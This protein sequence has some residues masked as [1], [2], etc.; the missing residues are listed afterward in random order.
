MRQISR[1][2][3]RE[4]DVAVRE[5]IPINYP[6]ARK[7][8][9]YLFVAAV[10][11]C[12]YQLVVFAISADQTR[13]FLRVKTAEETA[14][15]I[16]DYPAA[17]SGLDIPTVSATGLSIE[18]IIDTDYNA[19]IVGVDMQRLE[20]AKSEYDF[21]VK[22]V[23]DQIDFL[24]ENALN[25][26]LVNQAN[27]N[28]ELQYQRDLL[29][30][31]KERSQIIANHEE[32]LVELEIT[33]QFGDIEA[34]KKAAEVELYVAESE[35]AAGAAETDLKLYKRRAEAVYIATVFVLSLVSV[36]LLLLVVSYLLPLVVYNFKKPIVSQQQ[37]QMLPPPA[38]GSVPIPGELSGNAEN[39]GDGIEN[40]ARIPEDHLKVAALKKDFPWMERWF[41]ESELLAI[42]TLP[43]KDRPISIQETVAKLL[44]SQK[45]LKGKEGYISKAVIFSALGMGGPSYKWFW[46]MVNAFYGGKKKPKNKKPML[47]KKNKPVSVS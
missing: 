4:T 10:V 42:A 13:D 27:S 3:S 6:K 21:E 35:L 39:S 9:F 11:W 33:R 16:G 40:S 5:A 18:P 26:A 22:Q 19:E 14:A 36:S 20:L 34:D 31:E 2:S 23:Q 30:L 1:K 44:E 38:V 43:P 12:M 8:P 28:V 32:L 45:G 17:D 15:A 46:E 41:S 47:I 37:P 7:I 29:G 25:T 24:R